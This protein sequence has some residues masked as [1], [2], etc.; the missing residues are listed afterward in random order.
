MLFNV[1]LIKHIVERT[2]SL[3]HSTQTKKFVVQGVYQDKIP[4]IVQ[5]TINGTLL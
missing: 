1:G 2:F 5:R 3:R 4:F